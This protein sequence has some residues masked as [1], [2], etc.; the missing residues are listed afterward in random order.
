MRLRFYGN[1]NLS[2]ISDRFPDNHAG[3]TDG[4]M[5]G[6]TDGRTDSQTVDH[7]WSVHFNAGVIFGTPAATCDACSVPQ[8]SVVG[9]PT[10]IVYTENAEDQIETF[11]ITDDFYPFV[12][13]TEL[14][15]HRR[16]I[17]RRVSR[18]QEYCASGRRVYNL[19]E[20]TLE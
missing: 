1:C 7:C 14:Q 3:R 10:F 16:N 11:S 9:Q 2:P 19:T 17:D 15:R 13:P 18:I 8:V 5:A 6:R 20:I 12:R 4:R